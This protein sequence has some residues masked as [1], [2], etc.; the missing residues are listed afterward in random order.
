MSSTSG[1]RS[2]LAFDSASRTARNCSGALVNAWVRAVSIAWAA[3]RSVGVGVKYSSGRYTRT[4]V[5][6]TRQSKF[7]LSP[8][9]IA[10]RIE[11]LY[12][13]KSGTRGWLRPAAACDG[14]ASEVC[15]GIEW[16]GELDIF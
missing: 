8:G 2:R 5:N 6:F 16:S 10:G 11:G 3:L 7:R 13:L 14:A 9:D 15:C 4:I 12:N 1:Q